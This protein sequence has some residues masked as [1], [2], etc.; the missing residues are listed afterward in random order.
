MLR[1]HGTL[2][3]SGCGALDMFKPQQQPCCVV[4]KQ[5]GGPH[6]ARGERLRRPFSQTREVTERGEEIG[7][8]WMILPFDTSIPAFR[9][10]TRIG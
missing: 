8:M 1:W 10:W 5:R 3:L 6:M 2:S 7:Q 9:V 4:L